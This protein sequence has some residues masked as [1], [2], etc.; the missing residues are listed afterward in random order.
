M[1]TIRNLFFDVGG[2]V[3]DWKNT[4]K[5]EITILAQSHN[6]QVDSDAFAIDW[7]T[8]MFKIH[9]RVRNGNLPWMNADRMH[10]LALE[11]MSSRFPL[12]NSIDKQALVKST[13]HNLN[14]FSGAADAIERLRS[15][16]TV[17]VLTILNM[18]SIFNSSK[19]GGVIWDGIF[20]CELLGYYKPSLQAYE[21]AI[22][23]MGRLPGETAMVAAHMG[24][25]A[26]AAEVGMHTVY[27]KVPEDDHVEEG[28]AEA[29]MTTVNF[30]ADNFDAVCEFFKV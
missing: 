4:V 5:N 19:R 21:K 10:L 25:L 29:G 11:E 8:S 26:A 27:V 12:L 24:D 22:K 16:Y 13:W 20:S 30:E 18:E 9:G 17:M 2:T 23:M 15:K 7:R 14:V 6:Q 1:E 3:F 28:F